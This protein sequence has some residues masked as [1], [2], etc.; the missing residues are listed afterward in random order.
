MYHKIKTWE[1]LDNII[2][3]LKHK[4]EQQDAIAY[5]RDILEAIADQ[6]A[7]EDWDE[8]DEKRYYTLTIQKE[9]LIILFRRTY[10]R[11]TK[12]GKQ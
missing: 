4:G 3:F 8:E 9:T 12:D 6:D 1:P 11:L 2:E 5:F 7:A 10:K